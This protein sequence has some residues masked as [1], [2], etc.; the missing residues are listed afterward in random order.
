MFNLQDAGYDDMDEAD[1]SEGSTSG[2]RVILPPVE[3]GRLG[4]IE[5]AISNHIASAMLREKMANAIENEK[6]VIVFS[7]KS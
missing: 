1:L 7:E 3:M 5:L 6:W 4:E 2:S